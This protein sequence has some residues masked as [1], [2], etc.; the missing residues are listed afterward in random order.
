MMAQMTLGNNIN[1]QSDKELTELSDGVFL[2][3]LKYGILIVFTW[4]GISFVVFFILGNYELIGLINARLLEL[5]IIFLVIG[6]YSYKI[7]QKFVLGRLYA[8]QI[9]YLKEKIVIKSLNTITG[10]IIVNNVPFKAFSFSA[11]EST[12]L[13][14]GK[15]RIV[16]FYNN[17]ELIAKVNL[18]LTEW[19]G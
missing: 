12:S 2:S 5:L 6:F 1:F 3:I 11:K 4:L 16:T 15:Q 8:I 9:N 10:N 13:L 14:L 17:T 19:G 18:E 7:H